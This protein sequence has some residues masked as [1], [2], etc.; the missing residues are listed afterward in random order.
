MF[1]SLFL[2]LKAHALQWTPKDTK[3]SK[4][5]YFSNPMNLHL[6][7]FGVNKKIL[8]TKTTKS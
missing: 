2:V 5:L 8:L 1:F 4:S 7:H 3:I 6:Y